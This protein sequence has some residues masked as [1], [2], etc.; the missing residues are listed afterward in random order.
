MKSRT[1]H[2]AC[3]K[4]IPETDMSPRQ[5][6]GDEKQR[7]ALLFHITFKITL[8]CVRQ[9]PRSSNTCALS[10]SG[11]RVCST[12]STSPSLQSFAFMA[13]SLPPISTTENDASTSGRSAFP[14]GVGDLVTGQIPTTS[15]ELEALGQ[16]FGAYAVNDQITFGREIV[17]YC[18]NSIENF[19]G[20]E[21]LGEINLVL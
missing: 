14:S 1:G 7:N 4:H 20:S 9:L 11:S 16:S 19:L 5:V 15:W 12:G 8:S 21:G 3:F 10:P 18:P 2:G 6:P 13:S 17:I